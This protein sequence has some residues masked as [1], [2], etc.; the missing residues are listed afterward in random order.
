MALGGGNPKGQHERQA[1]GPRGWPRWGLANQTKE[2][3]SGDW[4]R[5]PWGWAWR[6]EGLEEV[7]DSKGAL[8]PPKRSSYIQ[9]QSAREEEAAALVCDGPLA[10]MAAAGP[11]RKPAW[12]Q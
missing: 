5:S 9:L 7:R 8:R 12:P 1:L 6:L 11:V 4:G 10:A 2:C 3:L